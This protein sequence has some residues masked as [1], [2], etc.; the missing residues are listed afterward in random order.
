V[1]ENDYWEQLE[2]RVSHQ[3]AS[4]ENR[5]LR[6]L[7]CDGFIPEEYFVSEASPRITGVAWIGN[8]SKQER[9]AFE[10]VLTDPVAR[11]EDVKWGDLMP[12][13]DVTG[14]LSIELEA[15]QLRMAPSQHV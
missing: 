7:W 8:G 5:A 13:E 10:L 15:R 12:R 1:T 11:R 6:F 9:W 2:F 4:M 14:W 3:F